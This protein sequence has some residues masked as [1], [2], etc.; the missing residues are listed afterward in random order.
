MEACCPRSLATRLGRLVRIA[1]NLYQGPQSFVETF[2]I[3]G[4][5]A[6]HRA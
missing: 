6:H 5:F 3:F 1:A 4:T 2:E